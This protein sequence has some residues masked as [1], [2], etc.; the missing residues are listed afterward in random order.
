MNSCYY[1]NYKT[2]LSMTKYRALG[3]ISE[4]EVS[5]TSFE[6]QRGGVTP[7][8]PVATPLGTSITFAN[9]ELRYAKVLKEEKTSIKLQHL[10][11]NIK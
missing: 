6:A 8:S 3:N 10:R 9:L 7:N 1:D 11:H 5:M 4:K 2:R